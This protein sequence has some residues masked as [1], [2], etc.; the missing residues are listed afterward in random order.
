[1]KMKNSNVENVFL[2]R[3]SIDGGVLKKRNGRHGIA[4]V[5][6]SRRNISCYVSTLNYQP[7]NQIN[8]YIEQYVGGLRGVEPRAGRQ[9]G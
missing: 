7:F 8:Y 4:A 6:P 3:T 5:R 2:G 1:M 9:E